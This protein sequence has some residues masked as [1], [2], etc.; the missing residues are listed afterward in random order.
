MARVPQRGRSF[1]RQKTQVMQNGDLLPKGSGDGNGRNIYALLW[2]FCKL[3]RYIGSDFCRNKRGT[4][5]ECP[6]F[7]F[8]I[9]A[10]VTQRG[11]RAR[12]PDVKAAGIVGVLR[13]D[14]IRGKQS[15]Q[16]R[17]QNIDYLRISTLP[18]LR[19]ERVD[20]IA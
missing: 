6:D 8:D 4:L 10:N 7:Q 17:L 9:G 18:G 16:A 12:K 19:L 5:G 11:K 2:E 15:R 1:G 20:G 13:Y 3:F 14:A